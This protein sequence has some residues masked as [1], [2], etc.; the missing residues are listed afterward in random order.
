MGSGFSPG[1]SASPGPSPLHEPLTL[2]ATGQELHRHAASA[3][4]ALRHTA[5]PPAIGTT[6]Q[7]RT[8]HHQPS[9][10]TAQAQRIRN[11]PGTFLGLTHHQPRRTLL[12]SASLIISTTAE[13]T[14]P[15]VP[16]R[17]SYANATHRNLG[18][19]AGHN[20]LHPASSTDCLSTQ[21]ITSPS[22]I[23]ETHNASTQPS[24]T[25]YTG[26]THSPAISTTHT[27]HTAHHQPRRLSPNAQRITPAHQHHCTSRATPS[28][29]PPARVPQSTRHH[30]PPAPLLEHASPGKSQHR[31][32]TDTHH[33]PPST[34]AQARASA[35]PAPLHQTHSASLDLGTLLSTPAHHQPLAARLPEHTTHHW[36]LFCNAEHNASP[37][38]GTT[39]QATQHLPT[40]ST[41]LHKRSIHD[42]RLPLLST[43]HH[44]QP[45]S[46]ATE[47]HNT[48]TNRSSTATDT[49]HFITSHP[50]LAAQTHNASPNHPALPQ[51]TQRTP[52]ALGTATEHLALIT[53]PSSTVAVARTPPTLRTQLHLS[54]PAHPQ[55]IST[56]CLTH[57]TS[58][59][60]S[61]TASHRA[62]QR[63][64]PTIQ[65]TAA[66]THQRITNRPAPLHRAR[67]THQP[68]LPANRNITQPL[69]AACLSPT[70]R[71]A[72]PS[73]P[74]RAHSASPD[75]ENAT[76]PEHT[77][78]HD[79]STPLLST[80][81]IISHSA[82]HCTEPHQRI[83]TIRRSCT[84]LADHADRRLSL[85]RA[86]NAS[87]PAIGTTAQARSA[88]PAI[89][90]AAE[91]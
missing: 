28:A 26:T 34:T 7:V 39:T 46:T 68:W 70:V 77:A 5:P 32:G 66:Q 17:H 18:M 67:S 14:T 64:S 48:S 62:H 25:R 41:P 33:Q 45:S 1:L 74:L 85:R 90:T 23:S 58:P 38:I 60:H 24:S 73:T 79:P 42:H 30:Q 6:A 71:S 88:S 16:L 59:A 36:P 81:R 37:A 47:T 21:R 19:T 27:E 12:G 3:P 9:S 22:G 89:G 69:D 40:A 72:S 53:N 87:P 2:A 51:S 83:L 8:T 55:P 65:S 61:G 15:P 35:I 80:Q 11:P 91:H 4:T 31:C 49:W 44:H 63:T 52:P 54:T 43:R 50:A 84:G 57:S 75:R 13:H 29:D 76:A 82:C 78:H 56:R 86:R 10:T 20:T